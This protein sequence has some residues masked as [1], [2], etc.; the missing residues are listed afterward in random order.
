MKARTACHTHFM[1]CFRATR[2]SFFPW[3]RAAKPEGNLESSCW[4]FFTEMFLKSRAR[5]RGSGP[6]VSQAEGGWRHT[7][8]S[9]QEELRD[10]VLK[11]LAGQ[12]RKGQCPRHQGRGA[13]LAQ[14]SQV[15]SGGFEYFGRFPATSRL[16][17]VPVSYRP[18]SSL[19]SLRTPLDSAAFA[20]WPTSSRKMLRRCQAHQEW[21]CYL[22]R[23]S[24]ASNNKTRLAGVP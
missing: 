5:F 24:R 13:G 16:G 11:H 7:S 4:P 20:L 3:A 19:A 9:P 1:L 17:G 8:R 18:H 6:G 22:R 14:P 12:P 23:I 15:L 2:S 21:W 10:L